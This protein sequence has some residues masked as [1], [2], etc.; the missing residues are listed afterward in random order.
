MRHLK[1]YFIPHKENDYKPHSLREKSVLVL[2]LIVVVAELG[3]LIQVFV[4]FDKTNFLAS[5]LPGVL[6]SLTNSDREKNDA[7][8]L[9]ENSLLV[10]AAEAKAQDM[11]TR[12]Y[13]A[14]TSPDGK[15]PWY[16]LDQ[17]G[18]KYSYAGENLAV[19][20][21]ESED[22]ERAWMNSPLHRANIVKQDYTE[23]GIGI[24]S[25]K[26]EGRNTIFV[27]QFFGKPM[28]VASFVPEKERGGEEK[29]TKI[30]I[31][32][33]KSVKP[34]ISPRVESKVEPITMPVVEPE[35]VPTQKP[36]E[37]VIL[38]EQSKEVPTHGEVSALAPP[39]VNFWQKIITSPRNWVGNIYSTISLF[40]LLALFLAILI[41]YELGHPR[42]IARGVVLV[43]II[44][45][46]SFINF[47]L[48]GTKTQV[49]S[50]ISANVIQILE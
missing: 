27:A 23:I 7:P 44:A 50:D 33:A 21:F 20:F 13:F 2:F 1:R 11:A 10:K 38:G 36:S 49:P 6:V 42:L 47:R 41:K 22:V 37:V 24:A 48:L 19:N 32:P 9:K 18:Y 3:F 14:H 29:T 8:P 28:A 17:V 40:M 30:A 43:T 46:L 12:G 35:I 16:W 26:F 4:I 15:T 25:G 34:A 45:I 31:S 5:V 39:K